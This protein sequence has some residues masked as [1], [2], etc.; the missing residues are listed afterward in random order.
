MTDASGCGAVFT[1]EPSCS[2]KISGS[3]NGEY[4]LNMCYG[5]F[6]SQH[7]LTFTQFSQQSGVD[8]IYQF[9]HEETEARGI[10]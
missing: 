3:N 1:Q 10:R 2:N 7:L 6:C 5:P 9:L 8:T 4:V